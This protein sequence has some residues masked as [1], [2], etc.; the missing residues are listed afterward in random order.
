M[1]STRQIETLK[2][3][4]RKIQSS[5]IESLKAKGASDS[6]T[7]VKPPARSTTKYYH[8]LVATASDVSLTKVATSSFVS[9]RKLEHACTRIIF[10][11]KG[12]VKKVDAE[13]K[14]NKT[15]GLFL[16]EIVKQVFLLQLSQESRSLHLCG[17]YHSTSKSFSCQI[18]QL[19]TFW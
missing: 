14:C 13:E 16:V 4:A 15:K 9:A 19:S 1:S 10:A 7:L 18:L 2:D 6:S 8:E 12:T 3:T 11:N 17:P 5:Q